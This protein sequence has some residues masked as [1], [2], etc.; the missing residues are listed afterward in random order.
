MLAMITTQTAISKS[1]NTMA[2]AAHTVQ[3]LPTTD[4]KLIAPPQDMSI[5]K[6]LRPSWKSGIDVRQIRHPL[7]ASPDR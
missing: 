1:S 7:P 6:T 3:V 5:G 2:A 4:F